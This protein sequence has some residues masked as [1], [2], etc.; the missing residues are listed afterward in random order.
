MS[1][2]GNLKD[3]SLEHI[4]QLIHSGKKTG[5]LHIIRGSGEAEAFVYFRKGKI[6]GAVSNFN[7]KPLGEMLIQAGHITKPELDQSLELQKKAKRRRKLG[8]ILISQGLITTETLKKVIR[9]QIQSTV[10]DLL[11]WQEGEFEFSDQLP[12]PGEMTLLVSAR[13][14]LSAGAKR[15]DE[16]ER[17]RTKVP[18]LKAIFAINQMAAE[19]KKVSLTGK[20]WKLLSQVNGTNTVTDIAMACKMNEFDASLVLYDLVKAGLIILVDSGPKPKSSQNSDEQAKD[21][22][23]EEEKPSDQD[24][25]NTQPSS[26]E[27]VSNIEVDNNSF[28]KNNHQTPSEF[29]ANLDFDG[30]DEAFAQEMNGHRLTFINE[31][32]SI[33]SNE[34]TASF[35][36][37]LSKPSKETG[38]LKINSD[39]DKNLVKSILTQLG[40]NNR[41]NS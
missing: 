2:E 23:L 9:K 32:R 26:E 36:S 33:T 15:M 11:P 21:D 39:V 20:H 10:F 18:S 35:A 34:K 4:F 25:S 17:V 14:V 37:K 7:R 38:D 12:P 24:D 5:T 28:F 29:K 13:K 31:L 1:L 30:L 22:H 40:G 6:F 19:N 16:W 27:K 3:F 8:Q 41:A